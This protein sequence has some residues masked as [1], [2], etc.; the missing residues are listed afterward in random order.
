MQLHHEN[1]HTMVSVD[2]GELQCKVRA[3]PY[4]AFIGTIHHASGAI[5]VWTPAGYVPRGYRVAAKAV[6]ERARDQIFPPGLPDFRPMDRDALMR[7]WTRYHAA[8]R[9]TATHLVGDRRDAARIVQ[10]LA[11]YACD[12]A[13][14]RGGNEA[15]RAHAA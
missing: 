6:L 2:P 7:F 10:R 9:K 1:T 11:A 12:L 5:R 4:A 8:S 14:V 15:Y 3:L 13:L